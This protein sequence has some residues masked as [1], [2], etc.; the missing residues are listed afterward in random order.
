MDIFVILLKN[1][2]VFRM[3]TITGS[4]AFDLKKIAFAYSV[5]QMSFLLLSQTFLSCLDNMTSAFIRTSNW[6]AFLMHIYEGCFPVV[7]SV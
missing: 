1:A 4:L 5:G 2:K 3:E 7:M 6:M